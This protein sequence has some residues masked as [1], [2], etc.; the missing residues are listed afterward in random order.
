MQR[1][2]SQKS[3]LTALIAVELRLLF[4]RRQE[5]VNPL[6]FFLLVCTLFPLAVSPESD[7]LEKIA[8]GVLWVA[9]TLASL[10][11]LDILF[12]HDFDDG[13]LEQQ[14]FSQHPEYLLVLIKVLC[15]W[16]M[17][18]FPLILMSPFLATMLFLPREAVPT[19]VISL[20]LGTPILALLGS[21][22]AALTLSLKKGGVILA[23]LVLP[24]FMPVLIFGSSAV[25]A[26]GAGLPAEGQLALL[27]GFLVLCITLAP[28]ATST[29]LHISVTSD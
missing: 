19:L 6:I 28:F 9:A 21:I 11:S 5:L 25:V 1:Q 17:S 7:E 27:G 26:A 2:A 16:L 4:R 14:G 29:A 13:S 10:L 20:I 18:G 22:G 12:R 15:Y 8:P 3:P 24:L 23:L